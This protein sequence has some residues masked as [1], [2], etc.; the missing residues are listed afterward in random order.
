MSRER[1][2]GTCSY[3]HSQLMNGG[4]P[5]RQT[6]SP[7]SILRVLAGLIP[8]CEPR[9]FRRFVIHPPHRRAPLSKPNF[10]P[11]FAC[12]FVGKH[13]FANARVSQILTKLSAKARTRP[14]EAP[15]ITVR[16]PGESRRKEGTRYR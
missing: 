3:N 8:P 11:S 6:A 2:H 5:D 16:L 7:N 12:R 9:G 14:F 13:P 15:V 10:L 1:S 4:G